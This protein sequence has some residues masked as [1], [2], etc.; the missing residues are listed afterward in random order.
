MLVSIV[1]LKL[2]FD[3]S[4][5]QLSAGCCLCTATVIFFIFASFLWFLVTIFFLIGSLSD[6]FI[7]KTLENATSSEFGP[8]ADK[9]LNK[10]L[11]ENFDNTSNFNLSITNILD[12]CRN[13]SSIY[14][15]LQLDTAFNLTTDIENWKEKFGID[16]TISQIKEAVSDT[17]NEITDN[18]KIEQYENDIDKLTEKLDQVTDFINSSIVTL[19]FDSVLNM[20]YL[21]DI[22]NQINQLPI[23]QSIKDNFDGILNDINTFKATLEQEQ[24]NINQYLTTDLEFEVGI[25]KK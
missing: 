12:Q 23:D 25:S 9:Y 10:I 2:L 1:L 13:D 15:I 3:F 16:A 17:L 6:H 7:C 24:A 8:V 11:N 18:I 4:F 21:E 14:E 5:S 20:T 19:D 22:E